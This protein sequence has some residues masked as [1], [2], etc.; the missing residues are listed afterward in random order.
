[1]LTKKETEKK[2]AL[3]R[4]SFHAANRFPD[5]PGRMPRCH[6]FRFF[7]GINLADRQRKATGAGIPVHVGF[8]RVLGF[9]L[10]F[11]DPFRAPVLERGGGKLT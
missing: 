1:M 10:E 6:S 2:T 4:F 11:L 7:A 5:P 3:I 9:L 8:F